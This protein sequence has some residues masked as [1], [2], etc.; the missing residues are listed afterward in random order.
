MKNCILIALVM[1]SL[2]STSFADDDDE[3]LEDGTHDAYVRTDSG[4]YK[5][6]VEIENGEVTKVH[7][8]NGGNMRV[9]GAEIDSSGEAVGKNSDG[10]SIRIEIEK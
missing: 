7:W 2:S 8:P 10:D 1:A 4:K 3:A 6:P 5:V 9:R